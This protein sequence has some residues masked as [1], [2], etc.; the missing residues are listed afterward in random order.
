MLSEADLSRRVGRIT[1]L[2]IQAD[3]QVFLSHSQGTVSGLTLQ[4]VLPQG[5][6]FQKGLPSKRSMR[7]H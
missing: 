4:R 5:V 3:P 2:V 1:S 7:L 6:F